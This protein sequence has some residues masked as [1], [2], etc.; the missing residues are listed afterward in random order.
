MTSAKPISAVIVLTAVLLAGCAS[1][2]REFYR[3][4]SG[5]DAERIASLRASPAP[6][7]PIVER[8]RPGNSD[9]ILDAYAKRGYIMI[10]N[11]MFNSGRPESEDSALQQSKDVGADLVLILNPNYTGSVTSSI[12]ITTPTTSTTYSNATATA[13]GR[14][15]SVTAYGSGVSTTYGTTT[16]HIPM[17]VHRSDYGAVYFIRQKFGLGAFFRDLNDSERQELQTNRGAVVRLIVDGTPA[18]NADLL[19]GDVFTAIDG[20]PIPSSQTLGELLRERSGKTV[21]LSLLRRGEKIE[22]TL[23]LNPR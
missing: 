18:F 19:V 11:S 13:Y 15:G 23:Q 21:V 2:Y 22:K 14:G 9:E 3:P 6:A 10:G 4:T 12:P 17:T 5:F 8:A 20:V 1:G 16:N 7:Q